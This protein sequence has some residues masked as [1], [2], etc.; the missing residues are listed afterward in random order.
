[1]GEHGFHGHWPNVAKYASGFCSVATTTQWSTQDWTSISIHWLP[2]KGRVPNAYVEGLVT[3]LWAWRSNIWGA[4][5]ARVWDVHSWHLLEL[6]NGEHKLRGANKGCDIETPL[7]NFTK[8][9]CFYSWDNGGIHLQTI[10]Q[11]APH[12]LWNQ[13]YTMHKKSHNVL[14]YAMHT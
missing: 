11:I 5:H 3:N 4:N 13:D 8:V 2:P 14:N 1:M 10:L 7:L 9:W 6:R 12:V